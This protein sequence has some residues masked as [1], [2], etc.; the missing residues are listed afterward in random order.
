MQIQYCINA[1][2]GT[3]GTGKTLFTTYLAKLCHD[4]GMK[5]FANYHLKGIPYTYIEIKDLV[6]FPEGLENCIVVLDE[7]HVGANAYDVFKRDVRDL[8][9][10]ATQIRKRKAYIFW[11]TQRFMRV[12]K[13]LRDLTE[14][15]FQM[16]KTDIDGVATVDVFSDP[17]T[18]ADYQYS[19]NFD[20]RAYFKYYDTEEIIKKE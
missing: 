4:N 11:T 13:P 19:F 12:A 8:E 5:V 17:N 2:V 18:Y 14:Y 9:I 15:A 7:G 1:V 6:K 3:F 16:T 10:F 20:G